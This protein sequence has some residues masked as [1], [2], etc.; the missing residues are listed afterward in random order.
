MNEKDT[1][2]PS[3]NILNEDAQVYGFVHK[4]EMD[5][6]REDVFRS[7]KEKFL[8]FTKMLKLS[9]MLKKATVTHKP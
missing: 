4:S 1:N 9:A 5:K 2:K 6:L 7:D 8:A 3:P